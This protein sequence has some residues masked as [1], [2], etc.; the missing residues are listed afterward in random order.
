MGDSL[1]I[2]QE[3]EG[4]TA[5]LKLEGQI[6]EGADY[7]RVVFDGIDL[8]KLDFEGVSLINSTGLQK[9]IAF[10]AQIPDSVDVVFT[11]CTPKI[12]KQIDMFPG[13]LGSKNVT[14]ENFYAP[15]YCESCDKAENVL[16]KLRDI[17][18]SR[19]APT[20]KCETCD[21]EMEFDSIE[22]KYFVFLDHIKS[23]KP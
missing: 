8:M 19:N 13:F 14:V 1:K 3:N 18:E 7:S 21:D 22:K 23:Q 20:A 9:W 2:V 6:D 5:H 15:Y 17:N 10:L 12:I 11:R 16:L 4:S